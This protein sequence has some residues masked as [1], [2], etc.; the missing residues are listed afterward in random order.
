MSEMSRK[1][2]HCGKEIVQDDWIVVP[3]EAWNRLSEADAYY[4]MKDAAL[5]KLE[6][7]LAE[8]EDACGKVQKAVSLLSRAIYNAGNPCDTGHLDSEWP[9]KG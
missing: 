1:C 5:K 2:P 4:K 6:R 7:R 8:L 9:L 3:L